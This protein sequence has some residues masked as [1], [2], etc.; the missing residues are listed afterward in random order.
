MTDSCD[1]WHRPPPLCSS[2]VGEREM[3]HHSRKAGVLLEETRTQFHSCHPSFLS[4]SLFVVLY[5]F[6]ILSLC[7]CFIPP[8]LRATLSLYSIIKTDSCSADSSSSVTSPAL[9][10]SLSHSSTLHHPSACIS[11]S[12]SCSRPRAV[13]IKKEIPRWRWFP[14]A[15]DWGGSSIVWLMSI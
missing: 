13:E 4:L 7:P 6:L 2:P 14:D 5:L 12:R 15:K 10:L 9:S 8:Y 3:V 11:P 1:D